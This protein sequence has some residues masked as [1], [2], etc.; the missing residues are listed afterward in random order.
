MK[1][2]RNDEGK[3]ARSLGVNKARKKERRKARRR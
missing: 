1:K 2:A 3:K